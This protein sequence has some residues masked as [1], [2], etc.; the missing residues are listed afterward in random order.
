MSGGFSGDRCA[1]RRHDVRCRDVARPNRLP[2]IHSTVPAHLT[3]RI[4]HQNNI[5]CDVFL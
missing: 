3:G 2:I 4:P 1:G 5:P